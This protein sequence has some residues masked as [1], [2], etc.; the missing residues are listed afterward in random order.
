ME[1]LRQHLELTFDHTF[2]VIE[3]ILGFSSETIPLILLLALG[4]LALGAFTVFWQTKSR[5]RPWLMA[6]AFATIPIAVFATILSLEAV[7]GVPDD[8]CHKYD[9]GTANM[10]LIAVSEALKDPENVFGEKWILLTVLNK[11]WKNT[12]HFCRV[13]MNSEAGKILS[14]MFF[15]KKKGERPKFSTFGDGEFTF[16]FGGRHER[17]NVTF[18]PTAKPDKK[19]AP[20]ETP[21]RRQDI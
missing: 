10:R 13:D 14:D 5:K 6:V 1:T 4:G 12:P 18:K 8:R 3:G 2:E 16:T 11:R 20:P 21:S 17:P 9:K 19:I 7:R 15:P